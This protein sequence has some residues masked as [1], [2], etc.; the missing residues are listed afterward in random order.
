[1]NTTAFEKLLNDYA[2]L[3]NPRETTAIK[4]NGT[5]NNTQINIY[6]DA[7]DD[8]NYNFQLIIHDYSDYYLTNLN[9]IDNNF[10]SKYLTGI[11]SKLLNSI[12]IDGSLEEF[13][14]KI[15]EIIEN[16]KCIFINY[17]RD[18]MYTNTSK[19]SPPSEEMY[20]KTL[21]H[22]NMADEMFEW[23]RYN[24]NIDLDTL[25]NISS[26]NLTFVRTPDI[27]KRKR[28][29]VILENYNINL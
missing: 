13:Y 21:S 5:F 15:E 11:S 25:N 6:F 23:A 3:N 29:R 18:S 28:L 14:I 22:K 19:Y 12:S 9:I 4:Y 8:N 20:L 1:M 7:W 2:S 24:T 17:N 10:T 27:N 16:N 26:S